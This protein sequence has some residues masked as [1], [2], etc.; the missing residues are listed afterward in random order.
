M[1]QL[2][3]APPFAACYALV[4]QPQQLRNA[5]F[6][7]R[8]A[9]AVGNWTVVFLPNHLRR[10]AHTKVIGVLSPSLRQIFL[11]RSAAPDMGHASALCP[12]RYPV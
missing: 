9:V 12:S 2:E 1:K 7:L 4:G 10:V 8:R 6:K 3:V 11:L 5:T